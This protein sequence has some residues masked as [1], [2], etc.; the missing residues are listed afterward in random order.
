MKKP[1][2]K[3]IA[4]AITTPVPLF[5]VIAFCAASAFIGHHMAKLDPQAK[6][7]AAAAPKYV[8]AERGTLIL[9]SVLSHPNETGE[10]LQSRV[11][12]PILSVLQK[13]AAQGYIVLEAARDENNNYVVAALPGGT[14]NIT[15]ELA[16]AID[17]AEID[18]NKKAEAGNV[19]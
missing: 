17:Q 15:K 12:E 8:I 3:R 2:T 14:R 5:A 4:S 16:D 1:I 10:Q 6:A 7:D 18:A 19:K 11:A 13:Y 9:Q